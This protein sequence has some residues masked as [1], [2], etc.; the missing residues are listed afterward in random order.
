MNQLFFFTTD[1]SL[2]KKNKKRKPTKDPEQFIRGK[3]L[4]NFK[5]IYL[6]NLSCFYLYK[7]KQLPP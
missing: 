1:I 4:S 6:S 5:G 3:M 7:N 2:K